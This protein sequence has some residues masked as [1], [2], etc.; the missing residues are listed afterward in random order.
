M[1]KQRQCIIDR[2]HRI[3]V[4]HLAFADMFLGVHSTSMAIFSLMYEGNY[5]AIETQIKRNI[6]YHFL[7]SLVIMSIL[8]S[9]YTSLLLV[10]NILL[11]TRYILIHSTLSA[12]RTVLLCIFG[13]IVI[14]TYVFIGYY[15]KVSAIDYLMSSDSTYS[16]LDKLNKSFFSC[17]VLIMFF[18]DSV[19]SL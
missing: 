16:K 2:G 15:K 4:Q 17:L 5:I 8:A 7:N 18:I 12:S 19:Y 14:I 9:K 11:A 13:W 10:L 6:L 1:M 3:L